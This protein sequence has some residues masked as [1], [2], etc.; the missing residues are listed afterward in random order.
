MNAPLTANVNAFEPLPVEWAQRIF[1]RLQGRFG[2]QFLDKY[3]TGETDGDGQDLG[4]MNAI[5]VWT[6]E[7][8]GLTG[9]EIKRGLAAKFKYPPSSD[10]FVLACRPE[11]GAGDE[12]LFHRAV[13]ELVKRRNRQPQTWPFPGL[14]WTTVRVGGDMLILDYKAI[15][16]RWRAALAAC[17]DKTESVPDVAKDRALP[18][19]TMTREEADKRMA[20]IGKFDIGNTGVGW[21]LKI[22]KD[23]QAGHYVGGSY[24]CRLAADALYENGF[25][26]PQ[27]L[28]PF[29][30]E[31]YR[32]RM[33]A[34]A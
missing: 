3:R 5:T 29:L 24:G 11:V 23:Q 18:A 26:V 1:Q 12:A 25:D 34:A 9:E 19:P 31:K 30:S 7:L 22:A 13:E 32:N 14:Y 2:N 8:A 27:A 20:E 16:G 33:E 4:V 17:R 21:A 15:S 28:Y 6:E 10:D